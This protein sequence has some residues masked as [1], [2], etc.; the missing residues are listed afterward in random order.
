MGSTWRPSKG[1]EI[2]DLI[3]KIRELEDAVNSKSIVEGA[4]KKSQDIIAVKKEDG[5]YSVKF[6]TKDGLI[7]S[8]SSTTTGFKKL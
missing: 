5:S 1:R 3:K 7:E 4:E 8:D 6:R 2:E